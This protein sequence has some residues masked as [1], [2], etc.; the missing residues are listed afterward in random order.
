MRRERRSIET[1]YR[2]KY[3][4]FCGW[5]KLLKTVKN[6][7]NKETM[8]LFVGIFLTG[9]RAMEMPTLV[10]RQI[11]LD[12]SDTDIMVR[13]MFV[14]KQRTKE[15]LKEDGK[16]IL[17]E[18]G[19]KKYKSIPKVAYR[20]FPIRRDNPLTPIFEEYVEKFNDDN[21][22]LF[23]YTYGQ[24][25]YRIN[26]IGVSLPNGY[27]EKGWW[28]YAREFGEWWIHRIRA[29]RACQLRREL[30]YDQQDLMQYFGWKTSSMASEYATMEPF[31]LIREGPIK[32]RGITE[33]SRNK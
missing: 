26:L 22:T 30:R 18:K 1:V 12:F 16:F 21:D 5:P 6:I 2:T 7:R 25:N 19:N 9:G 17:D 13:A 31:D 11:D 29:E 10:R 20:D 23:P 3:S 28:Y 24:M 27:Y 33:S 14:E 4:G 8:Y 15:F 32:R